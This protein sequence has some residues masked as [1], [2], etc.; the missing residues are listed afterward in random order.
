VGSQEKS[1]TPECLACGACCFS[2][3]SRY[4][5]VTGDDYARLGDAATT[6]VTWDENRAYMRI[7]DGRCAALRVDVEERRF[8]C[9]IYETR[10]ETCRTLERGSPQCEGE[11]MT[12]GER[13]LLALTR[14]STT[15]TSRRGA[16][17]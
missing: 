6:L 4:V 10:P 9:T 12:K 2:T 15:G 13:P 8:V 3:L 5:P 11:R 16:A 14:R 17:S 1:E 7:A